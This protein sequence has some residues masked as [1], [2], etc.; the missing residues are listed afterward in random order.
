MSD[1]KIGVLFG[2]ED[3]FP[4]ALIERINNRNEKD[5]VAEA[6]KL[7]AVQMAAPSGYRLIIDRISQDVPFYRAFL[8]NAV[9]S[10]TTVINNPFWWSADDKFF[11]YALA[12]QLGVAIPKTV[13][14]PHKA[15]SPDIT[16]NPP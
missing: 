5:I 6:V 13:L 14:L 7:G 3:T 11:N 8:K 2:R 10:G 1:K 16:A 4:W 15:A 9:L 12:S